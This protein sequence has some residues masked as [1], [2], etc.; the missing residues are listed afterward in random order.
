MQVEDIDDPS[1]SFVFTTLAGTDEDNALN[2]DFRMNSSG[3]IIAEHTLDFERQKKYVWTVEITDADARPTI[4]TTTC[5]V[6]ITIIDENEFG[7]HFQPEIMFVS[8]SHQHPQ[9]LQK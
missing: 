7:P 8:V 5:V 9:R 6:Q 2:P 4:L 1:A 3:F